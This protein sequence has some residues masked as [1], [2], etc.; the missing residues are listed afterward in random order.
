MT[1]LRIQRWALAIITAVYVGG[2]AAPASAFYLPDNF[3]CY[4]VKDTLAKNT[5]TLADGAEGYGTS[6]FFQPANEWPQLLEE[7]CTVK[8][9]PKLA[10]VPVM[11]FYGGTNP[12]P[13]AVYSSTTYQNPILCYQTKCAKEDVKTIAPLTGYT[14]NYGAH[15]LKLLSQSKMVC[16]KACGTTGAAC[17]VGAQCCSE[18]CTANVCD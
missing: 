8:V 11:T 12:P 16:A 6:S 4:K 17:Y 5:Y 9:P 14:D 3:R 18:S 13:G 2:Y 10:C 15:S 1:R 7:G